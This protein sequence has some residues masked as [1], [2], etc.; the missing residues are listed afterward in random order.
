MPLWKQDEVCFRFGV[1]GVPPS[2]GENLGIA[3]A[4]VGKLPIKGL[5]IRLEGACGRFV[6]AGWD[7]SSD[8]DLYQPLHVEHIAE[9]LP[10]VEP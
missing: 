7:A 10:S 9:Y 1:A 8:P 6:W 2:A 5:R 3:F 4:T